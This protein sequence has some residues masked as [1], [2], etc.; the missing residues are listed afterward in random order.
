MLT[1]CIN[2]VFKKIESK[3]HYRILTNWIGVVLFDL[4]MLGMTIS[5]PNFY[6][7]IIKKGNYSYVIH[8]GKRSDL[9]KAYVNKKHE[10]E[11]KKGTRLLFTTQKLDK[12]IFDKIKEYNEKQKI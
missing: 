2:D 7:E 1:K 10:F 12:S 9:I 11:V 5:L 6:V 3:P 8:I 4:N